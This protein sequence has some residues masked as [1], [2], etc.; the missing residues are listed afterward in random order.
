MKNVA[1]VFISL[2]TYRAVYCTTKT[3]TNAD[4]AVD[5][6]CTKCHKSPTTN[7]PAT[8]STQKPTPVPTAAVQ[9]AY[10]QCGGIGWTGPTQCASGYDCVKGSD[11]Y[12]QCVPAGTVSLAPVAASTQ[13][14]TPGM[15]N[16]YGQCGGIGWTGPTQCCGGY[17]CV[18]GNDY[19]S[20]CVPAGTVSLAPVVAPTQIP[21]PVPT[22]AVQN[23]YGQCGG[24]GW[25]GPTQCASGY[26]CVKGSDYYSQCVPAGTVSLAPVAASTQKPTPGMQN[27]Y[28]Q[29]GGIG[30]TGPTQCCGGYICV[31]GND[32]YS[33]CVPAGTVSLAPVVAPT[34]IPTPVPTAAVQNA[35]GQCGGIGWTG[36]AQCASGYDCVKGN[37][38]YSQCVPAGTVSLA[39]VVAPTQKPAAENSL[40]PAVPTVENSLA[41]A[42]PTIVGSFAPAVPTVENSLAPAVPTI[43]GSFAPAVPTVENSLAP[44]VPTV[45]NSFAPAVPSVAKSIAPA[46]PTVVAPTSFPTSLPT[47]LPTSVPTSSGTPT[48]LP[49]EAPTVEPTYEPTV[50]PTLQP[51]AEPTV[52]PSFSPSVVVTGSPVTVASQHPVIVSTQAPSSVPNSDVQCAYEQCGGIGWTGPTECVLGYTCVKGNDWYSQCVPAGTVSLAPVVA[53][54]QKPTP[55]ANTGMQNSYGQCGG[56]GWTGPTQCC[57]GYICVKGNDWYSQCVPAGTVSLAPVVAPTQKP[58]PVANTG[59]QNSYGQCGGI[60]WTGP[61][62]CCG[63]Y[64]CVKGNDWYSQCVPAGTVSLAPVVAPTQKPTPVANTGIQNAYGQCGGIGWAGPTQCVSGY[65]C[66]KGND[67]YFQCVPA[68]S[69]G[70]NPNPS[71][72]AGP[73]SGTQNAYGQCGGIGWTGPTQ[74]VSGF[75]CVKG[76]DWYHQCVPTPAGNPSSGNHGSADGDR[77]SDHDGSSHSHSQR[78]YGQCGGTGWRGPTHC[79]SGC[80]CVK[81]NDHYHHCAPQSAVSHSLRKRYLV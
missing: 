63:G 7:A 56:I 11:Y 5:V 61:T 76:N 3:L 36:P 79:E 34:Q 51:T 9:N 52:V 16:S 39:P 14:P 81:C 71:P 32:Y 78:R 8:A 62:Q 45:E 19:Y 43:V 46:V 77:G 65:N 28:G 49:T 30:W 70:G 55:V 31:K 47:S 68:P 27:S 41:P 20:Q 44:A 1:L 54:T 64:I 53:P 12:S 15:Q 59:M 60:G 33:Q 40:A 37:D 58:T 67:W 2:F 75:C 21:T 80:S 13:K 73:S 23:A 29:C 10:G 69:G 42:L 6:E 57:G 38:Y 74:C 24:I 22:A 72:A 17:I 26:D 50:E 48:D 35:Y 66:V 4:N 18:K 25:T